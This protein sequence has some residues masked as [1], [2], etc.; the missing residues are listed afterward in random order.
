[1]EDNLARS[2]F[3]LVVGEQVVFA[4]YHRQPG[5]LVISHVYAPIPLRGT[6]AAG[7][8][9]EAVAAQA[10]AEGRRILARCGYA[11]SWLRRH[12]VHHNLL[13]SS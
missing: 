8:L 11:R 5:T 7:V 9:M 10:Q 3:E 4:N 12:P 1:M 2:R 13:V 6:G